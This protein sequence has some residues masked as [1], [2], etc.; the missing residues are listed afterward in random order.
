MSTVQRRSAGHRPAF[1]SLPLPLLISIGL[2]GGCYGREVLSIKSSDGTYH[3]FHVEIAETT[4]QKRQGLMY[5]QELPANQGMLFD[6]PEGKVASMWMRNTYIALDIL[7]IRSDG[8]IAN[9]AM[10]TVPHSETSV[11]ANEAVRAV[12]EINGGLSEQLGIQPGNLVH[13]H[14]FDNPRPCLQFVTED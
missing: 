4:E 5:I 11:Y 9:I 6:Y 13:H 12:F 3:C 10:R 1:A 7:F 8:T 14:V 2:L